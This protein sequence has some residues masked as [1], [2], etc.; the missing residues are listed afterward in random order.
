VSRAVLPITTTTHL[1]PDPGRVVARLFVPGQEFAGIEDPKRTGVGARVLG[2][3]ETEVDDALAD[4]L[5]RFGGHNDELGPTLTHHGEIIA[6]RLRAATS[7]TPNRMMLLGA[8]F[9]C[10]QSIEAAALC[11]P[12]MVAHPDQSDLP[13]GAL[14]FAMSVRGIAEG[15]RSSIGFRTGVV[16]GAG[17]VSVDPVEPCPVA[18]TV[19]PG[20]FSKAAFH[21]QLRELGQDGEGAASVLDELDE[22]FTVDQLD[23]ELNLLRGRRHNARAANHTADRLRLI[24]ERTYSVEF[25]LVGYATQVKTDILIS[26][27]RVATA[28]A[29]L[30]EPSG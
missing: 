29:E 2:L 9:T 12:S 23:R 27:G 19:G 13:T 25:R 4:V 8:A 18:G 16:D 15:H 14:R 3:D 10:E 7:L 17:V 22:E 26:P 20:P 6:A 1:Q 5:A 24:S 30:R 21:R 28:G 11:N